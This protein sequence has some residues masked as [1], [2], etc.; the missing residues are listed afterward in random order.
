MSCGG[1]QRPRSFALLATKVLQHFL[2]SLEAILEAIPDPAALMRWGGFGGFWGSSYWPRASLLN[3]L[4]AIPEVPRPPVT[5]MWPGLGQPGNLSSATIPSQHCQTSSRPS[6]RSFAP[7]RTPSQHFQT[8]S[9]PSPTILDAPRPHVAGA[10]SRRE[11]EHVKK[12]RLCKA[13]TQP[14]PHS[15]GRPRGWPRGSFKML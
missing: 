2:R 9:R 1:N 5:S 10:V 6:P 3:S 13:P 11:F 4:E 12:M 14:P 15:G 7:S 8:P